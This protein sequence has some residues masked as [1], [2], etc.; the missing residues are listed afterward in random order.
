M[1]AGA[2]QPGRPIAA[3]A[4]CYV[5]IRQA[6]WKHIICAQHPLRSQCFE[7]GLRTYAKCVS[8][9]SQALTDTK[10][11]NQNKICSCDLPAHLPGLH[12]QLRV[13]S[14]T[15]TCHC[16][17]SRTPATRKP[18]QVCMHEFC[19]HVWIARRSCLHY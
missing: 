6:Y 10:N 7:K 18:S 14:S 13:D 17:E 16:L 8:Q 4:D 12:A 19:V 3:D 2:K 5:P 11:I 9:E 15:I 1:G